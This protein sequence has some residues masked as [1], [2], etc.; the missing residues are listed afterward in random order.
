[1][2]I[3][4]ICGADVRE[5]STGGTQRTHLIYEALCKIGSVYV[6]CFNHDVRRKDG[7]FAPGRFLPMSRFKLAIDFLVKK[8]FASFNSDAPVLYPFAR[9]IN[10]EESFPGVKFDAVVVRYFPKAG[11]MRPWRYGPAWIDAD[12]HPLQLYDTLQGRSHG[13]FRRAIARFLT[14]RLVDEIIGHCGGCWVSNPEQKS[15][16]GDAG[17]AHVLGNIPSGDLAHYNAGMWRERALL[18]VGYLKH[19]PNIM[20]VDKFLR[21]VW[22]EI[23]TRHPE[24]RY[25]IAGKGLPEEYAERWRKVPGVEL[26]GF[27]EN[28]DDVYGRALATVVPVDSGGGTCIKTMESLMRSRVCLSTRFGARGFPQS[29]LADGRNGV[30]VYECAADFDSCLSRLFDDA[31]RAQ[32]ETAAKAYATAHFSRESFDRIVAECIISVIFLTQRRRDAE[33]R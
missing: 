14:K 7:H 31:E 16:F 30:M 12:D 10:V 2:N 23:K 15:W 9:A 22:P 20:G 8:F 24:L 33:K 4:Y 25:W 3:L 17:K 5:C 21:T 13:R 28:L 27:V 6:L 1:M 11:V 18:T 26:L 19:L 32:L 29:A